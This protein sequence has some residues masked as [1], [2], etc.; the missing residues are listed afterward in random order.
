M[1]GWTRSWACVAGVAVLAQFSSPF[2][3]GGLVAS[4]TVSPTSGYAG[5]KLVATYSFTPKG[6]CSAYHDQVTWSFGS[7]TNWTTSPVPSTSGTQCVSSTPSTA[8][9]SAYAPGSYMVCGTDTS[10]NST[11][12]C[13]AYSIKPPIPKAIASPSPSPN[14]TSQASPSPASSPA[15]SATPGVSGGTPG[16]V[17]S[18]SSTPP[19][20]AGGGGPNPLQ[21]AGGSGGIVGWP[22]TGLLFLLVLIVAAWRFRSWLMGV[23]ENVVVLGKSGADLETE[24]LHHETSPPND[25]EHPQDA[26]AISPGEASPADAEPPPPDTNAGVESDPVDT[27]AQAPAES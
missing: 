7:T 15:P 2:A 19:G 14:T 17:A 27:D 18:P 9:P 24:L 25:I 16:P 6:S 22:W 20:G 5:A 8:P 12:A 11:P 4:A 21:P 13:T 23:F 3:S 26:G 10:V 1:E